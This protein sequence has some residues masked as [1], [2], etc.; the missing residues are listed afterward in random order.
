[1]VLFIAARR[2][3]MSSTEMP[4]HL[5]LFYAIRLSDKTSDKKSLIGLLG[6]YKL[7]NALR[8]SIDDAFGIV[9]WR[10]RKLSCKIVCEHPDCQP[11]SSASGM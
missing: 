7:P 10:K 9:D 1:M 2:S 5:A 3:K 8:P 6:R 4:I 11:Q